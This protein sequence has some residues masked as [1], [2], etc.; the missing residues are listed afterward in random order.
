M[1]HSADTPASTDRLHVVIAGHVIEHMRDPIEFFGEAVRVLKPG[2]TLYL[3]APSERSMMLPGM[4]FA[5][6]ESRSLSFW[7]DPT[8]LGRPWPPQALYRLAKCYGC[9]PV[10]AGY[11]TSLAAKLKALVKVP[12]GLVLKKPDWVETGIWNFTGWASYALVR[13]PI[14]GR[15][16][17]SFRYY[18]RP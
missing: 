5:F 3:E 12:L 9:E 7:D 6:D 16:R 4:W 11:H 14:D 1:E 18:M 17:P 10:A 15:G 2:G 8:H 13:K